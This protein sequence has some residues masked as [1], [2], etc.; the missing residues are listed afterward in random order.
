MVSKLCGKEETGKAPSKKGTERRIGAIKERGEFLS[1][2]SDFTGKRTEVKRIKGKDIYH[3][4]IEEGIVRDQI[5][6]QESMGPTA[7]VALNPED[8]D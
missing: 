1:E 2:I 4:L 3:I 7:G 5:A 6:D 8:S